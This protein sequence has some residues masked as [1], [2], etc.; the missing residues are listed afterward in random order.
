MFIDIYRKPA[1]K[2]WEEAWK[3][4]DAVLLQMRDEVAAKGARLD[5]V[6]LSNDIQVYPD[7]AVRN[8]LAHHPGVED[9][10]YPDK[11]LASFCQ[12]HDI[13]VLLLAQRF[14]KYADEHQVY[15]HGFRTLFRN[16][17][18]SG[19]WNRNGHRLAGEM[20]AQW[21]CPQINKSP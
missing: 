10:F 18:G 7:V 2:I 12:S 19:H 4:T 17:L 20:I 15:L 9:V 1:D 3:V 16:T 5:V 13:P 14:Q 8:K 11:R 6:V 21:L